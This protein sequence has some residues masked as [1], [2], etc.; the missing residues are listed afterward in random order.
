MLWISLYLL[1]SGDRWCWKSCGN[2]SKCPLNFISALN[3]PSYCIMNGSGPA[4]LIFKI[5][6]LWSRTHPFMTETKVSW[7]TSL[8]VCVINSDIFSSLS[9]LNN[10]S[11]HQV[12]FIT[13]CNLHQEPPCPQKELSHLS[14]GKS[15]LSILI[16]SVSRILQPDFLTCLRVVYKVPGKA[17]YKKG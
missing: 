6:I 1:I 5:L 3:H 8:S 14:W 17:F 10:W 11:T 12:N 2:F 7:T 15:Q 16:K 13:L 4:A 9:S